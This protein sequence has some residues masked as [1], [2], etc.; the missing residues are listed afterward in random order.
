MRYFL[1]QVFSSLP[2]MQAYNFFQGYDIPQGALVAVSTAAGNRLPEIYTNPDKF[3]PDRWAEPRAEQKKSPYAF[4]AFG[5]GR[6]ACIGESFGILQ[7]KTIWSWLLRNYDIEL[8][9]GQEIKP[10]FTSMVVSAVPPIN[11]RYRRRK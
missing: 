7:T 9:E 3:D 8:K 4:M 10:D 6:H 5:G 1:V 2:G 11:V